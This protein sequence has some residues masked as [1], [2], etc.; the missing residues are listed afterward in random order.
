MRESLNLGPDQF[1]M[2]WDPGD[3]VWSWGIKRGEGYSLVGWEPVTRNLP[4]VLSRLLQ[5]RR[6]NC[7]A[8]NL[9]AALSGSSAGEITESPAPSSTPS[10]GDLAKPPKRHAPSSRRAPLKPAVQGDPIAGFALP[11]TSGSPKQES[12]STQ[13]E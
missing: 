10:S 13:T 1:D 3:N 5:E 4:T 7:T 2:S 11:S 8:E 12:A 6:I 9:L